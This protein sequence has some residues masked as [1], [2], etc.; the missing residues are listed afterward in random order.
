MCLFI[1]PRDRLGAV[2][3]LQVREDCV[4]RLGVA[5]ELLGFIWDRKAWWMIPPVLALLVILVLIL[6]SHGSALSPLLYPLF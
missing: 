1:E 4:E 3:R 5:G 2:Y 6:F